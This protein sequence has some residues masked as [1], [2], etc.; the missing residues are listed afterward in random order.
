MINSNLATNH[1]YI[2]GLAGVVAAQTRL[3]HVDGEAGQLVIA[4]F[5][6]EEIAPRAS[7][8]EMVYLLWNDALPTRQQLAEFRSRLAQHS[9]LP[10]ATRTVLQAA[11]DQKTNVMDAF[12][13]AADT[14]SLALPAGS[15][16]I[17]EDLAVLGRLPVI[18]ASY[19]RILNRQALLEPRPDLS[20]TANYLY[21]LTGKAPSKI[22]SRARRLT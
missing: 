4:G 17:E 18:V 7:F 9:R 21:M 8:E 1:A 3:S 14:I 22:Y 15:D 12:R 5:P 2:P 13:M 10:E 11:A 20:Y 19:W 16:E 6:L